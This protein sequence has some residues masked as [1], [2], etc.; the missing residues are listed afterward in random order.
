M[1][2][3]KIT[4]KINWRLVLLHLAATFFVII[5]VEQLVLLSNAS[6][7]EMV[8]KYGVK[9]AL[10]QLT[11]NDTSAME[12]VDFHILVSLSWLIGLLI[13]FV[14]SLIISIKRATW[15][16]S[17]IVL[18]TGV[19]LNRIGLFDNVIIGKVFHAPGNI[20]A[21]YGLKYKFIVNGILLGVIGL[22]IFL[23]DFRRTN[24][25]AQS[26]GRSTKSLK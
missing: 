3:T 20:V 5:A 23:S 17:I 26:S 2:L 4:H 6:I 1:S 16:T 11:K 14:L 12:L 22:F 24:T 25:T 18:I 10:A 9:G 8:E 19:I 21:Q 7:L 13:S 15:L